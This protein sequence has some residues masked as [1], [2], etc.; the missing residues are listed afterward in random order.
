MS[1]VPLD[2][3]RH[4]QGGMAIDLVPFSEIKMCVLVC[5]V[6]IRAQTDGQIPSGNNVW[7]PDI[8]IIITIS[9]WYRYLKH[10]VK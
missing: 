9:I 5:I 10:Y 4:I 8:I 7:H 6:N 1:S 2:K 3:I